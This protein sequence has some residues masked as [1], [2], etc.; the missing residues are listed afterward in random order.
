MLSK[1]INKIRALI[2]PQDLGEVFIEPFEYQNSKKFTLSEDKGIEI[3]EV[4]INDSAMPSGSDYTY[5]STDSSIIIDATLS[6]GDIIKVKYRYYKYSDTEL[7]EYIRASL[8]WI[9]VYTDC[10]D[11][12]ELES[13]DSGSYYIYPTPNN[14]ETDLMA[15]ISAIQI[16]PDY[17]EYRLPNLTVRYQNN[18]DKDT[19]IQKLVNRFSYSLGM[20]KV[21]EIE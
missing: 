5:D 16:N 8:V 19:K 18:M 17:T 13:D 7:T 14:R 3:L 11:D 9:S 20:N 4:T 1:I 12:F 2:E 6:Q 15:L 10:C 21:L